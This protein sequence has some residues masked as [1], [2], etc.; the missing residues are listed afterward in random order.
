MKEWFEF[1]ASG[2]AAMLLSVAVVYLVIIALCR[3]F[4]LR[5]FSKMSASDFAVTV[6]IGSLFATIVSS[7]D[8]NLWLG[9]I[10]LAAMYFC[11]WAAAHLRT[12]FRGAARLLDNSP[13]LLVRD[14]EILS[15]RLRKCGV[16]SSDLAAKLR[17][18]NALSLGDVAAVVFES[19]GDISV[20]HS[21]DK[22]FAD[23]DDRLLDGV[24]C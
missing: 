21:G 14:G 8:P 22:R 17:E 2:I 18:A 7:P 3:L 20:L 23:L 1:S 4:G 9:L 19:T 12:R 6:A 10:S 5:S 11:K 24:Q 16:S 13:M 15:D